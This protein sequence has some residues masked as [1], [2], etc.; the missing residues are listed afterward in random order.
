MN[1]GNERFSKLLKYPG[2]SQILHPIGANEDD[3]PRKHVIRDSNN[4]T[5]GL[6]GPTFAMYGLL[7]NE[8]R[9]SIEREDVEAQIYSRISLIQRGK[10]GGK[11][12]IRL[13]WFGEALNL[14]DHL[15]YLAVGF[16]N[17]QFPSKDRI[18][19][20]LQQVIQVPEYRLQYI[21][22]EVVLTKEQID[23]LGDVRQLLLPF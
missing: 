4:Q 14:S 2:I 15:E 10:G 17:S 18:W 21:D 11:R 16:I 12:I 13:L 1:E 19:L 3:S 8:E 7:V 20:A 9:L 6:G 5:F 22:R 23:D